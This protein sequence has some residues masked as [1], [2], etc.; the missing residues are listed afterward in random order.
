MCARAPH[1]HRTH[2]VQRARSTR[3]TRSVRSARVARTPHAARAARAHRTQCTQRA[4]RAAHAPHVLKS[5][6]ALRLSVWR[7]L[8]RTVRPRELSALFIFLLMISGSYMYRNKVQQTHTTMNAN[9]LMV[10][11]NK[12]RLHHNKRTTL[13][14]SSE[15]CLLLLSTPRLT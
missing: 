11:Y 3:N 15:W 12:Q 9:N 1:A 13:S 6:T 4:Q 2:R 8:F 7:A 14:I 10:E 5:V